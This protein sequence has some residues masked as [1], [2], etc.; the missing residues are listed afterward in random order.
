MDQ[1]NI[2]YVG[3]YVG[4]RQTDGE[5]LFVNAVDLRQ[6]LVQIAP[7]AVSGTPWLNETQA[8]AYYNY[9]WGKKTNLPREFFHPMP[10]EG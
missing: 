7:I 1:S 4:E 2:P 8:R 5:M 9:T 3:D 10:D 6:H